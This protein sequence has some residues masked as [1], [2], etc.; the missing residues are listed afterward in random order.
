MADPKFARRGFMAER[1]NISGDTWD[2]Y[3]KGPK[4]DPG[5]QPVMRTPRG[6]LL[7][8]VAACDKRMR[9]MLTETAV[10]ARR[11]KRITNIHA[12]RANLTSTPRAARG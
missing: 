5:L 10:V 11:S 1:Y 9:E 12:A 8:D 7:W 6:D 4:A 2:R 3:H